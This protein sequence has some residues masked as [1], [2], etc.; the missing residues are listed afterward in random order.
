MSSREW[1]G[2]REE[3]KERDNYECQ[4]CEDTDNLTLHHIEFKSEGGRNELSNVITICLY[5]HNIVHQILSSGDD[6]VQFKDLI[7]EGRQKLSE[8]KQRKNNI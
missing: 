1:R 2:L 8:L 3:C 6:P 5:C 4:I 7:L